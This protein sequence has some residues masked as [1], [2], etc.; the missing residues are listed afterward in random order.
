MYNTQQYNT[1]MYWAWPTTPSRDYSLITF[2][3]ISLPSSIFI[4]S[5]LPDIYSVNGISVSNYDIAGYNGSWISNWKV[6]QK[7]LT[8]EGYITAQT[9]EELEQNIRTLQAGIVQHEKPFYFRSYDWVLYALASCTNFT[10]DRRRQHI[11]YIPCKFDLVIV[12]PYMRSLN[13]EEVSYLWQTSN[14]NLIIDNVK[15]TKPSQPII[16]YSINSETSLTSISTTIGSKNITITWS[17]ESGDNIT[18]NSQAKL[19]TVN[20]INNYVYNWEFPNIELWSNQL[21]TELNGTSDYDLT[22]T[23]YPSYV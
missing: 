6:S 4:L 2:N 23:R 22:V 1:T 16:S 20:G 13:P 19:V 8:I 14:L 15:G 5:N 3:D 12:D 9:R 7:P 11:T 18:I 21:I 17:F 10:V